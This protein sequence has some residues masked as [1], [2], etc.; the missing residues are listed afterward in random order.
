M[1]PARGRNLA[2]SREEAVASVVSE[3]RGDRRERLELLEVAVHGMQEQLMSSSGGE[4]AGFVGTRLWRS[5]YGDALGQPG[6]VVHSVEDRGQA[7][8]S[9][10]LGVLHCDVHALADGERGGVSPRLVQRGP[11]D[12]PLLGECGGRRRAGG[13]PAIADACSAP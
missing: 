8:A 4:V 6:G 3:E 1:T 7:L 10:L 2:S 11:E 5:A 9:T 12:A 13:E